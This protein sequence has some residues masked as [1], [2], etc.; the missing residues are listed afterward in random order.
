MAKNYDIDYKALFE[1]A[2]KKVR[3]QA[4]QQDEY[5]ALMQQC[6]ELAKYSTIISNRLLQMKLSDQITLMKAA[7][8]MNQVSKQLC[9]K[10][11]WE[12]D[13]P[14]SEMNFD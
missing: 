1:Q 14:E 6:N 4:N 9:Q 3:E 10:Y 8:H 7:V 11:G 5:S 13:I 12:N 2:M